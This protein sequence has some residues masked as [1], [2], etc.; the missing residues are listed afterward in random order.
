ML[1]R[2]VRTVRVW[3]NSL[4]ALGLW[5]IVILELGFLVGYFWVS[6]PEAE[7]YGSP[8][9]GGPERMT[10][11]SDTAVQAYIQYVQSGRRPDLVELRTPGQSTKDE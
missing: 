7:R 5:A 4:M 10:G 6:Q 3:A 11:P 8:F 9:S 2:H 1:K